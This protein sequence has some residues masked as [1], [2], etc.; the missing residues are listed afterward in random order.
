MKEGIILIFEKKDYSTIKLYSN[1]V[2]VQE[3]SYWEFR[4]FYFKD[5]NKA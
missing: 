5:L 2:D 4:T 1:R 3:C